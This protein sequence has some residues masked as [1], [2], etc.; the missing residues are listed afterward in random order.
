MLIP[1]RNVLSHRH[2]RQED[3]ESVNASR[4]GSNQPEVQAAVSG[5]G[6]KIVPVPTDLIPVR[7]EPI[8]PAPTPAASN[9]PLD[10]PLNNEGGLE[11]VGM[12]GVVAP[13]N[14]PST[15]AA[16]PIANL[17]PPGDKNPIMTMMPTATPSP[18]MMPLANMGTVTRP[19]YPGQTDH[20]VFRNEYDD[21]ESPTPAGGGTGQGVLVNEVDTSIVNTQEL[22]QSVAQASND[23]VVNTQENEFPLS[24]AFAL[25]IIGSSQN[26][27]QF[28]TK[29]ISTNVQFDTPKI[30]SAVG[31]IG[32]G[33]FIFWYVKRSGRPKRSITIISEKGLPKPQ[34]PPAGKTPPSNLRKTFST[35]AST[36]R[37]NPVPKNNNTITT[38]VT[39]SN[40]KAPGAPDNNTSGVRFISSNSNSAADT[41]KLGRAR[42]SS[43]R[44]TSNEPVELPDISTC[45]YAYANHDRHR[46]QEDDIPIGISPQAQVAANN[47]LEMQ[48]PRGMATFAPRGRQSSLATTRSDSVMIMY[49]QDWPAAGEDGGGGG[50]VGDNEL[51]S[52]SR[53]NNNDNNNKNHHDNQ[54][55]LGQGWERQLQQAQQHQQQ[56]QYEFS[57]IDEKVGVPPLALYADKRLSYTSTTS[58]TYSDMEEASSPM[59]YNTATRISAPRIPYPPQNRSYR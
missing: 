5:P 13:S 35:F 7:I 49:V 47:E 33:L 3:L 18:A 26:S 39:T 16:A 21:S 14:V 48:P 4:M 37:G 52:S 40:N 45:P 12:G 15:P 55:S 11:P 17:N 32:I 41:K 1:F 34:G 44:R 46:C 50:G 51:P 20:E 22:G 23:G 24:T 58:S 9:R 54:S 31:I 19:S 38:R 10:P 8:L 27:F 6:V 28:S 56:A 25:E 36:L 53:S 2:R 43:S 57:P 30:V 29:F 42:F 59:T